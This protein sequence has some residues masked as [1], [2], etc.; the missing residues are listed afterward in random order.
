MP[1][2]SA[3]SDLSQTAGSNYP[4]GSESP[5]TSD[6]YFRTYAAFIA[7]LRDGKGFAAEAT[8]ASAAT[9]DIGAANSLYVAI[10]GTTTITSFGA[11]YNGPR[12]L[13]F[14]G[15]LTLTHNASSLILPGG[16]NITTAAGD[17]CI[18]VPQAAGWRVVSYTRAASLPMAGDGQAF[19]AYLSASQSLTNNVFTKIAFN[20]EDYDTASAYDAATNHRFQPTAAGYYQINASVRLSGTSMT[21]AVLAFYKNGSIFK[22]GSGATSSASSQQTSASVLV[23]LN[24]STD[25]VQVYAYTSAASAN[26]AVGGSEYSYF[27]GA[28]VRAA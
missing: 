27:Q 12:F 2:P 20:T 4:A 26:S 17:T 5:S 24:G 11:N 28:L 10:T 18:V 8:V 13:R 15:A 21:D 7:T 9:A 25:Y 14:A 3:I 16:A 1:V 19:S 22:R 6:D 23:Y